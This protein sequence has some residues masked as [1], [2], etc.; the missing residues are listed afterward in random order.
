M[1]HKWFLKIIIVAVGLVAMSSFLFATAAQAQVTVTVDHDVDVD[2]N[3]EFF[4]TEIKATTYFEIIF[5]IEE[6]NGED[7]KILLIAD[8]DY[9]DAEVSG[10]TLTYYLGDDAYDSSSPSYE[11]IGMCLGFD[12]DLPAF[13]SLF[14]RAGFID[15]DWDA[16]TWEGATITKVTIKMVA[17]DYDDY[18]KV[19]FIKF[20][21]ILGD[22]HEDS[23]DFGDY[24]DLDDAD[25]EDTT[26]SSLGGPTISTSDGTLYMRIFPFDY[27]GALITPVITSVEPTGGYNY[28]ETPITLTG[29]NFVNGAT[30]SLVERPNPVS[31]CLDPAP[32]AT[33][34]TVAGNYAY[35][36][37]PQGF[38][39]IDI[40]NK[41]HPIDVGFYAG[42]VVSDMA[43]IGNYAYLITY[44]FVATAFS[45][46]L[47]IIDINDKA[48]PNEVGFYDIP[49]DSISYY[50]IDPYSHYY[51]YK[52]SV[53]V[54]GNYA[55]VAAGSSKFFIIDVSDKAHPVLIGTYDTSD[56]AREVYVEGDFAYVAAGGLRIINIADKEHPVEVG[57]HDTSNGIDSTSIL[58]F[59]VYG[60]YVYMIMS[61]T[62]FDWVWGGSH[63]LMIIDVSDRTNPIEVGTYT[64]KTVPSWYRDAATYYD[65]QVYV[66]GDYAYIADDDLRIIDITDKGH[67]IAVGLHETPG[68]ACGLCVIQDHAIVSDGSLR[69]VDIDDKAHPVEAGFYGHPYPV[70]DISISGDYAY[71]A[72]GGGGFKIV[73][74][75]NKAY[76][77]I[78]GSCDTPGF[79]HHVHISG[80]HA[81][82]IDSRYCT[83]INIQ[84]KAHPFEEGSYAISGN[85]HSVDVSGNYAYIAA[86]SDGLRIVDVTDKA[87]PTEVG[88]YPTPCAIDVHTAGNYAYVVDAKNGLRIIDIYDKGHPSEIGFY[89]IQHDGRDDT[90][91]L[92][93]AGEYVYVTFYVRDEVFLM[94]LDVHDK[95][96][97]SKAGLYHISMSNAIKDIMISG[98]YAYVISGTRGY[99][100]YTGSSYPIDYYPWGYY[101]GYGISASNLRIIDIHDKK[102]PYEV[103]IYDS[104]DYH[105]GALDVSGDYVYVADGKDGLKIIEIK[106]G[107][108]PCA[109]VWVH[110]SQTITAAIP[111]GLT[112]GTYAVTVIDPRGLSGILP[113][114]F[115]ILDGP[116]ATPPEI[117]C[118][119]DIVKTVSSAG[120]KVAV[121]YAATVTDE[122][123]LHPT[124]TYDPPSGSGFGV[125]RTIV[126]V[127][128]MDSAGNMS[129]CSFT[130]S[131]RVRT[132]EGRMPMSS[133]ALF[134][135]AAGFLPGQYPGSVQYSGW[136][137]GDRYGS[138]S[139][140]LPDISGMYIGLGNYQMSLLYPL[141]SITSHLQHPSVSGNWSLWNTPNYWSPYSGLRYPQDL[142]WSLSTSQSLLSP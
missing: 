127:T 67:P 74:I 117:T 80:D 48:H 41:A 77:C 84:D 44:S 131:I 1:Q 6:G 72:M 57:F 89:T 66:M 129:E 60:H 103:G 107:R 29:E 58:D 26:Y 40:G 111:R 10:K 133:F 53:Y 106:L 138:V 51:Q 68:P 110:D 61:L 22:E 83:I 93:V 47:R 54:L 30:V 13:T 71:V 70:Q 99:G 31:N 87:H 116:D 128:A 17:D 37:S 39:I 120:K 126:T 43:V 63:Y 136:I 20:K 2:S 98:D 135:G 64:Y 81:Y 104:L 139:G 109:D 125:G 21:N 134:G 101:P 69:I 56:E 32:N 105:A 8:D 142:W 65:V 73:N 137:S 97:P 24:D 38:S 88:S 108:M 33:N 52:T 5:D 35:A 96:S 46:S 78:L 12:I 16:Y 123:D 82:V 114:A 23:Q 112:E 122:S 113:K 55:Y 14:V 90:I 19:K 45:Y 36:S 76:P 132:L 119:S 100:S 25:W 11:E 59:Y 102:H 62:Y 28:E 121:N 95:A 91:H 130:V 79:A 3:Y 140:G 85:A 7:V 49:S 4:S 94:I 141:G 115:T 9:D 124:I 15:D 27:Q 118:P 34:V 75:Y 42:P 18:V 92:D 50:S 86:D